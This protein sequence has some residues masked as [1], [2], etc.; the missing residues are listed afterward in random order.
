[1]R[2]FTAA[3]LALPLSLLIAC[4]GKAG[5]ECANN[6][7]CSEG[8]ACVDEACEDVDC[9][10][11]ADCDIQQYCTEDYSCKLG[12]DGDDDCLA[13]QSCDMG[14]HQCEAYGCRDTQLDCDYGEKC[15]STTGQ[16]YVDDED[17]CQTTCD[18]FNPRCSGGD[19]CIATAYVGEC[20]AGRGDVGCPANSPCAIVEVDTSSTCDFFGFP[21]DSAC[22]SGWYCDYLEASTGRVDYYCHKDYCIESQCL[23]TCDQSEDC[24]R[25]FDCSDLGDGTNACF[26]DCEYL[27][28]EGLL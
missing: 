10:T 12:C 11:S 1:M 21:D 14:T 8:Q 18:I 7:D 4:T 9:V 6:S 15:D 5:G 24:P 17:L 22:P 3:L 13:G 20:D 16:C 26:A 2:R 19:A 25:G 27:T 23:P 28:S